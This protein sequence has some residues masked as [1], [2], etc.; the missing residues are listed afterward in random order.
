MKVILHIVHK[1]VIV[2]RSLCLLC[3]QSNYAKDGKLWLAD[4]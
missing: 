1:M 2:T 4:K 3:W